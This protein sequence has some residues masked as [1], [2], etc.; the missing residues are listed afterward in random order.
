M[1]SIASV[2]VSM[3]LLILFL[4][5]PFHTGVGGIRPVAMERTLRIIDE[6]LRAEDRN[7]P[8][9]CDAEGNSLR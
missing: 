4:N 2:I 1:G 3:L 9:P 5:S 7:L 6:E 8:L